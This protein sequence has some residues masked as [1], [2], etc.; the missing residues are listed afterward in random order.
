VF[1]FRQSPPARPA[2]SGCG[3]MARLE[4]A[5]PRLTPWAVF[6]RR[7]AA[8]R[9]GYLPLSGQAKSRFRRSPPARPRTTQAQRFALSLGSSPWLFW[10]RADGAAGSRALSNLCADE[11]SLRGRSLHLQ[12]RAGSSLRLKNGYGRDD[13]RGVRACSMGKGLLLKKTLL[14]TC[15]FMHLDGIG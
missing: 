5:R 6:C 9:A 11:D 14:T 4:V 15:K 8:G 2:C 1:R 3:L 12:L 10:L 7:S 13:L